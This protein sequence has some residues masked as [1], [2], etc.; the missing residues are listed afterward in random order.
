MSIFEDMQEIK[1]LA[2][3][4]KGKDKKNKTNKEKKK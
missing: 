1:K 2:E 4:I 3:K